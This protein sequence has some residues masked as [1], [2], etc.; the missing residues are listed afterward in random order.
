[1]AFLFVST[2]CRAA[3]CA[4]RQLKGIAIMTTGISP[5]I[6]VAVASTILLAGCAAPDGKEL[7]GAQSHAQAQCP[8]QW[9]ASGNN[10]PKAGMYDRTA[11]R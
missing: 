6:F 2:P 5:A 11:C 3:S 9:V 10:G 7:S 8:S 1:M 4:H